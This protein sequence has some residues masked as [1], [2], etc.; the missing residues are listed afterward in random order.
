M[1][2]K[3]KKRIFLLVADGLQGRGGIERFATYFVQE[4]R[5]D[6]REIF[7]EVIKTRLKPSGPLKHLSTLPA[8]LLFLLKLLFAAPDLCHVNVAPRGSTYRKLIYFAACKATRVPV[9][10]HL[11]GSGYDEYFSLLRYPLRHLVKW[12]FK[13]ADAVAVLGTHWANFV[14][15]HI[16]ADPN[17]V[18]IVHNG[19]PDKFSEYTHF[20]TTT[21]ILFLGQL[22]PRKGVDTLL[23]SLARLN[24][25]C[26]W[27]G[28]LA[29]NGDIAFWKSLSM[30]L[31]ISDKVTFTGWLDDDA[32]TEAL[33]SAD[34]LA[35]PSRAENQP[36][37]I[38]E[39][40]ALGLPV[41]ASNIG[42]I[43]EQ[44][45]HGETGLLIEP[46]DTAG[47]TH[48]IEQIIHGPEQ[49]AMMGRAGRDR[50][51]SHFSIHACL[52]KF[53]AI[54]DSICDTP[55]RRNGCS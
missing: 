31:G 14:R 2:V 18:F 6:N 50:Y 17:N 53:Q 29:G 28:I 5:A 42:A 23:H 39:A 45:V 47:L 55:G 49:A 52:D 30:S 1:D 27:R 33:K 38:I 8:F 54:Y 4:S 9:L 25:E 41:I 7:V 43:P 36:V 24:A 44:V 20:D 10:L 11:H 34:V 12:M 26:N 32:V 21:T 46:D 19:V 16:G 13:N 22:G 3:R 35:L 15:T 40:M 51:L 37:S 48:A